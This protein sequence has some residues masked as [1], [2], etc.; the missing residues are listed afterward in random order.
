M[1]RYGLLRFARNDEKR[2]GSLPAF[3]YFVDGRVKPGH[4]IYDLT[5]LPR[6]SA[7]LP[8]TT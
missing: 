3:S 8:A 2:P 1:P 5:S 7:V 4:D 6:A